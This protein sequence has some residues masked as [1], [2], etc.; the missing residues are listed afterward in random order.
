MQIL[1]V[2]VRQ[3]GNHQPTV[4]AAQEKV[5]LASNIDS[6]VTLSMLANT[7]FLFYEFPYYHIITS[8]A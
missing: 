3:T 5:V 1:H 7:V 4:L 6:R 8:S 2:F